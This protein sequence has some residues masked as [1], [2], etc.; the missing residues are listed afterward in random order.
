MFGWRVWGCN[1]GVLP[2]VLSISRKAKPV[3]DK[4]K[5]GLGFMHPRSQIPEI[6]KFSILRRGSIYMFVFTGMLSDSDCGGRRRRMATADDGDVTFFI[7]S[8]FHKSM[9]SFN[10]YNALQPRGEAGARM[11]LPPA[12][13]SLQSSAIIFSILTMAGQTSQKSTSGVQKDSKPLWGD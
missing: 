12:L 8:Q 1:L 3:S 13:G 9:Y 7:H 11:A 6:V 10:R 4:S 5:T 2:L